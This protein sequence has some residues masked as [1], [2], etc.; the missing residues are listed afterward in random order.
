[1]ANVADD[2]QRPFLGPG[3][4]RVHTNELHGDPDAAGG[5]GFPDLTEPSPTQ[6]AGKRVAGNG[7]HARGEA[8]GHG[9]LRQHIG[10]SPSSNL[11]TSDEMTT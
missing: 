7:D 9:D 8:Q 6:Q 2:F 11:K 1:M 10:T 3:F 4:L 5:H